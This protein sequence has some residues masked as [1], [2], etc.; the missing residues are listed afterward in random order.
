MKL[1]D[2]VTGWSFQCLT[3][4]G[5]APPAGG[6]VLQDVTHAGHNFA[7]DVRLIGLW[8]ET[9][10]VDPSGTSI[11]TDKKFYLLDAATFAV[12]PIATI[13]PRRI[14]NPTSDSIFYLL[15][16]SDAALDFRSYFEDGGNGVGFG[17]SARFDAP[18]LF[19]AR[20]NCTYSGL[21]VEQIFLFSRYANSPRH[22]PSGSLCAARFHPMIRYRFLPNPN[23]DPSQR[24]TRVRSIRFDYRLH[25]FIDRH[26]D[27]ALNAAIPQW[28]NNAAFFADSDSVLRTGLEGV[29]TLL[30]NLS[31]ASP[32][33]MPAALSAG[34]FEAV[35]KPLLLEV[36][37]PGLAK[38]FPIFSTRNAANRPVAVRCWDNIHWWG[39][40]GSGAAMISTPGAFHAAHLHWRWGGASAPV[41]LNPHFNPGRP[42]GAPNSLLH[43]MWGPIVDPAIW[44]QTLRIAVA[45]N[46]ARLD[47]NRGSPPQALSKADWKSLFD[48]GLGR[49]PEKIADGSDIVLWYSAEVHD[50]VTVPGQ[51]GSP[52]SPS[53]GPRTFVSAPGGTVFLHGIFFAHDAEQAGATAGSTG[54]LHS[55]TDENAILAAKRWFRPAG[56]MAVP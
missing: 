27:S 11:A 22:E 36:T 34:L 7:K 38:G 47:P 1:A 28:G 35:E 24:A 12:S 2:P 21:S 55:P 5:S 15:R 13:S 3:G 50:E 51:E 43:A 40:R 6:L 46:D 19:A 49:P 42:G 52:G 30:W 56:L 53:L 32:P 4:S 23:H 33:A 16:E 44:I 10:D 45:K 41:V 20:P 29:A 48:P 26:F 9:E 31:P 8:I 39:N 54:P 14:Y 17:A 25:L 18:A 37:A